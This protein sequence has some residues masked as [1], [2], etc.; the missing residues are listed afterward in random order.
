MSQQYASSSKPNYLQ[1][2]A[3][4]GGSGRQGRHIVGELL[5][6]G[7]HKVTVLT[8]SADGDFPSGAHPAVVNYDDPT[9]IVEAL[10]GQDALVITMNTSAP[11]D[12]SPKLIE[13]AAKAGVAWIIP[14]EWG[15]D[16][17]NIEFGKEVFLGPAKIAARELIEK[18]GVSSWTAVA[19]GYWYQ[20]SLGTFKDSFGFDL[21]KREATFFDDGNFKTITSTHEQVGRAVAS[22]LSMKMLLEGEGDTSVCLDRN[23]K[24]KFAYVKSFLVSQKDMFESL[25]RVT[26]TTDDDWKVEYQGAQARIAEGH[27]QFQAGDRLGFVKVLYTRTMCFEEGN[28]ELKYTLANDSLGL[29]TEDLD[30]CTKQAVELSDSIAKSKQ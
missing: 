12:T 14:D 15:V 1:N 25:K 20:Y 29:P 28:S 24:N 8:R 13:A 27:K 26:S 9:T 22:L 10:K 4:V 5:K 6:T 3:V 19:C 16:T 2:V 7:K 11:K 30:R 17:T 23:F 18:L 21:Q